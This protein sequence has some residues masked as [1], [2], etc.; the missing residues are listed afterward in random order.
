MGSGSTAFVRVLWPPQCRQESWRGKQSFA[1]IDPDSVKQMWIKDTP[2]GRLETPEDV[3]K[4]V[5]FLVSDDAE[6]L[7]GESIS[8][9]G[10]AFMD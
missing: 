1:G 5:G 4:V 9:N 8:V 3:A 7:T 10:G 6:F 2:L